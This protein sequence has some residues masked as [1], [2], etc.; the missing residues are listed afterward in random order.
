MADGQD[1]GGAGF[2]GENFSVSMKIRD[3]EEKQRL[4]KDRV[5]LIG[6]N[7]ISARE[8]FSKDFSDVHRS[9]EVLK[10]EVE[11][12]KSVVQRL[13]EEIDSKARKEDLNILRRQAKMFDP[14][15]L[16]TEEDVVRI[17]KSLK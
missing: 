17:V 14:L 5:L 4:L 10:D 13:S 15:K 8:E 6:D 16:T 1:V 12:L 9:L 2:S 11:R 3:L 7:L